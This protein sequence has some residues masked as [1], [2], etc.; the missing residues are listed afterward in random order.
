M[1]HHSLR[2]LR[3]VALALVLAGSLIAPGCSS[4]DDASDTST[5]ADSN[6]TG[7]TAPTGSR[8]GVPL[9]DV[10][11]PP[12]EMVEQEDGTLEAD[13]TSE[14][15]FDINSA[16]LKPEATTVV[17]QLGQN[18]ATGSYHVRVDGFTDGLGAEDYN[19]QLSLERA[20]S[21]AQAI[22][23]LGT[24][25]HVQACG[26]GEEGTDGESEDPSARRVVI[27]LSTQPFPEDCS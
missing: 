4:G 17:E 12:L 20:Q 27:T 10:D 5:G 18:L 23:N 15:L 26:R 24:A 13:I 22:G 16:E 19:L 25:Q 8:Q 1:R 14:A 6:E 2:K 7:V 9:G 11:L 21:L 3:G